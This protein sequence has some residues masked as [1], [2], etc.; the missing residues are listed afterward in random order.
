MRVVAQHAQRWVTYG[1]VADP[2]TPAEWYE[3]VARQSALL[4]SAC[5]D[6]GRDPGELRRAVTVGL[7]MAWPVASVDAFTD[8]TGRIRALGIT[9]VILHWPRPHDPN[10]PGP[11]PVIFDHLVGGARR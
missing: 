11:S 1:P 4:E 2:E 7:E 6:A 9:D 5:D 3:A 10:L 8:F